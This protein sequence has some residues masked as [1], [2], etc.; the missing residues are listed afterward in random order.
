[1]YRFG[2]YI[3][4]LEL[5]LSVYKFVKRLRWQVD[6]YWCTKWDSDPQALQVDNH[7]V[8]QFLWLE[9]W[10]FFFFI[11]VT[12]VGYH[13]FLC[14]CFLCSLACMAL[15]ARMYVFVDARQILCFTCIDYTV[16][17]YALLPVSTSCMR[18]RHLHLTH[19]KNPSSASLYIL[20]CCGNP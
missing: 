2:N 12:Q 20:V 16:L 10:S 1:M 13:T 3:L 11:A 6:W 15:H 5:F 18:K 9:R 19:H 7:G 8:F 17:C 14:M 4:G